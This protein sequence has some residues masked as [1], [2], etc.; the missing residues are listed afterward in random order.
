MKPET[1]R[2]RLVNWLDR[3]ERSN[4]SMPRKI[5]WQAD[6]VDNMLESG[7]LSPRPV[8]S[9]SD[10]DALGSNAVLYSHAAW[11][12]LRK[13]AHGTLWVTDHASHRSHTLTSAEALEW[14]ADWQLVWVGGTD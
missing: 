2:D 7:V 4:S 3:Y 1:H 10:L 9:V 12:V 14:T 13:Q 6:L 11:A 8:S 5:G